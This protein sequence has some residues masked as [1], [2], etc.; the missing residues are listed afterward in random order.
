MQAFEYGANVGGCS[1]MSNRYCDCQVA[2]TSQPSLRTLSLRPNA[3]FRLAHAR[4][5]CLLRNMGDLV[6]RARHLTALVALIGVLLHVGF[7]VRHHGLSLSTRFASNA[8]IADLGL[9]CLGGGGT[10][11]Q[12]GAD[13]PDVP[14]PD[15]NWVTCPICSGLTGAIA[16]FGE[17]A[18]L[19]HASSIATNRVV[20]AGE[21]ICRRSLTLRPPTRAP[22]LDI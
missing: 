8:L 17:P 20:V 19:P 6:V 5:A 21:A 11:R 14:T 15:E 3:V 9:I 12:A 16:I 2:S 13:F 18:T 10:S 22:P 7:T 4:H 1:A